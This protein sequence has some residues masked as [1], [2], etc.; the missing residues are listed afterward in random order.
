M[1]SIEDLLS[2]KKPTTKQELIDAIRS[3]WE[4]VTPELCQKY[5]N[6]LERVLPE[7]VLNNGLATKY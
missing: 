4:T 7:V 6:H 2:K 5:I 3:F 1:A